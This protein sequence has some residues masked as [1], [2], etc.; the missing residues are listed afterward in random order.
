M[1]TPRSLEEERRESE[2]LEENRKEAE[3]AVEGR[4]NEMIE[5]GKEVVKGDEEEGEKEVK[6]EEVE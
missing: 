2:A 3:T 5:S 4:E 1:G 6:E